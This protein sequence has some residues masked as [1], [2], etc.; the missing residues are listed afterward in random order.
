MTRTA[1]ITIITKPT[2]IIV[3]EKPLRR[4]WLWFTFAFHINHLLL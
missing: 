1:I 3:I 4:F 2:I